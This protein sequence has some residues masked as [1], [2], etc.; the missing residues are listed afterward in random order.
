MTVGTKS[1]G[2]IYL[3]A[4][5]SNSGVCGYSWGSW[6]S[7]GTEVP[8]TLTGKSA[9][10]ATVTVCMY[11][12]STK[13]ELTRKTIS[14]QVRGSTNS[15][16][17]A[18]VETLTTLN[19]AGTASLYPT[20]FKGYLR[21]TSQYNAYSDSKGAKYIGRIFTS[22]ELKVQRVYSNNGE[23]WMSALCP[24]VGY[25]SDRLIYTKLDAVVDTSFAPY[26]AIATSAAT[27]YTRANAATK[28]GSLDQGDAV[29]VVGQSGQYSQVIYPLTVGGYKIGWCATSSLSRP[30]ISSVTVQGVDASGYY[31]LK[32]LYSL[33]ASATNS[34]VILDKNGTVLLRKNISGSSKV[35]SGITK[36][37][38]YYFYIESQLA[39]GTGTV[40]SAVKK[41]VLK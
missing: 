24:W 38:T 11:D 14:I 35:A 26:T 3:Q 31:S 40:T 27:T 32:L 21:G 19:R 23:L 12:S 18:S 29:T 13:A 5:N 33:P 4:N 8:L 37:A 7:A 22:D 17:Q 9:G 28:Y 20:V 39:N 41:V 10:K 2:T 36:N 16:P 34:M 1:P 25:S 15:S 30:N 6:N